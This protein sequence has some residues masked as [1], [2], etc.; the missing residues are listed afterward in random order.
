MQLDQHLSE[1]LIWFVSKTLQL[2]HNWRFTSSINCTTCKKCN[3]LTNHSHSEILRTSKKT[4]IG[5]KNW[6]LWEFAVKIRRWK[7]LFKLLGC[8]KN[9]GFK[10]SGF[11]C[12]A[13]Q[14]YEGYP[15]RRRHNLEHMNDKNASAYRQYKNAKLLKEKRAPLLPVFFCPYCKGII[16][17]TWEFKTTLQ[18]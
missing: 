2:T 18:E 5:F 12:T 1:W 9:W 13:R 17:V 16:H 7:W 10:I 14:R 11:H 8:L 3:F 15:K 6:L 4:K